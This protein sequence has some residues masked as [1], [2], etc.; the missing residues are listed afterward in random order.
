MAKVF[1]NEWVLE[2]F[3]E[4]PSFRTKRMFGGLAVYLFERQ[5]CLLVEPTQSGRWTWHGVLLCTDYVNQPSLMEEFPAFKPHDVLKKWLYIDSSHDDFES[6]MISVAECMMRNDSRVGIFPQI[7]K[8]AKKT[9]K[10]KTA[11]KAT[12]KFAK[13]TKKTKSYK[14][15]RK[16]K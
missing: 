5:M 7:K 12:K 4:H 11:K 13:S 9:A 1:E 3:D 16:N 8:K 6:T 14:K 15:L 2:G 10:K